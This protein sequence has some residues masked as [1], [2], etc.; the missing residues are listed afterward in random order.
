[1]RVTRSIGVLVATAALSL[2]VTA[3]SSDSSG[4]SGASTQPVVVDIT[5]KGGKIQPVGEVVKAKTGQ[6][7][8]LVVT[9]D[10]NDE[11][12]VHSAPEHE[13]AVSA[14]DKD[15]KFTFSVDIPGTIVV[16]SHGLDLTV[17]KL[18]VS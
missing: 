1:M 11:I 2:G 7:I 6:D 13:F 18:Q 17:L 14:G 10:A 5:E 8:T 15:K 4:S 9:S 16:E 12:H 3:C